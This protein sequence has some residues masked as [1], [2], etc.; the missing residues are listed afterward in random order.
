[1]SSGRGRRPRLR[2][3]S[4]DATGTLIACP[5][6]SE[7]YAEVLARHGLDLDAERIERAFQTAWSEFE[8]RIK[9][10]EDRYSSHSAGARGFWRERL[11]RMCLLA[12]V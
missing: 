5:R 3:V 2:G 12:D 1:V 9:G 10:G 8:C 11:E 7:I 4:L 6:R